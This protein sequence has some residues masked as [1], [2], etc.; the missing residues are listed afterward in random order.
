MLEPTD[1]T[2]DRVAFQEDAAVDLDRLVS[3]AHSGRPD[4]PHSDPNSM[5]LEPGSSVVWPSQ[6]GK[7]IGCVLEHLFRSHSPPFTPGELGLYGQGRST[8]KLSWR[9]WRRCGGNGEIR[10]ARAQIPP[11][12]VH[13]C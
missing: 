8:S 12:N 5:Q 4:V 1:E 7:S 11:S 10:Y 13:H 2:A 9:L 6:I 3:A